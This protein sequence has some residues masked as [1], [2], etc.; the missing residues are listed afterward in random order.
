MEQA[1][2]Q[3]VWLKP[4]KVIALGSSWPHVIDIGR[5]EF[6]AIALAGLTTSTLVSSE[7]A[8][9]SKLLLHRRES[10]D[11]HSERQLAQRGRKR[12][13]GK[14]NPA[15]QLRPGSSQQRASHPPNMATYNR[16]GMAKRLKTDQE[17]NHTNAHAHTDKHI[18]VS[19]GAESQIHANTPI[20]THIHPPAHHPPTARPPA[21]PPAHHSPARPHMRIHRVFFA[22]QHKKQPSPRLAS[23]AAWCGALALPG[24]QRAKLRGPKRVGLLLVSHICCNKSPPC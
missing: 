10:T 7:R 18:R 11:E 23:Q 1:I 2:R 19:G 6:E 4:Y 16:R 17:T 12:H 15:R 22:A 5:F 3:K 24:P 13:T 20:H 8:L 21:R 14:L 9:A